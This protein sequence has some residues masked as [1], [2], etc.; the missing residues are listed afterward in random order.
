MKVIRHIRSWL[1]MKKVKL[2]TRT[3]AGNVYVYEDCYKR[4]WLYV[5]IFNWYYKR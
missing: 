3:M 5:R 4:K 1:T 2:F